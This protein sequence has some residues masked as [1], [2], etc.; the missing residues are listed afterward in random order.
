[1]IA[2][3]NRDL[4]SRVQENQFRS[5]LYY[6]LN[7][8]PIIVPPLRDRPEDIP[9]LVRYF[10]QQFARRMTKN[11]TTIPSEHM[12]ALVRYPWPGNIRELQN[13]V[14]R[15]V[16]LS[17]G[18][19][20]ALPADELERAAVASASIAPATVTAEVMTLEAAERQTILRALHHSGGR[21]GGPRGAA[22]ALGMKRTTLQAR[23]RKLGIDPKERAMS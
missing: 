14:E 21:V 22:A 15:A 9:M 12:R 1:V 4:E 3:T 19:V 7:V 5:D 2:A 16:I 6:R 11:I 13:L 18:P 8:F 20:L 17:T 10:V 23:M